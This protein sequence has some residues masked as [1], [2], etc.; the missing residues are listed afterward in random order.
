MRVRREILIRMEMKSLHQKRFD[1][2]K[3]K[4]KLGS[5]SLANNYPISYIM[6]IIIEDDLDR[7][8]K[9]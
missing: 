3:K 2:K 1:Q 5:R 6:C 4:R 8:R 9:V 7:L